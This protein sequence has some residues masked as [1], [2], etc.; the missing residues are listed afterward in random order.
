MNEENCWPF[1][2]AGDEA[3][4][5]ALGATCELR[6]ACGRYNGPRKFQLYFWERA[7][8]RLVQSTSGVLPFILPVTPDPR[9]S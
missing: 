6:K 8:V 9:E 3:R 2:G 1:D 4:A 7:V 5:G